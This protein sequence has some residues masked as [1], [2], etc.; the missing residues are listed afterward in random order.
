MRTYVL[1]LFLGSQAVAQESF[2]ET[3]L[4]PVRVSAPVPGAFGSLWT[5]TLLIRNNGAEPV[6]VNG[7]NGY[8]SGL[9]CPGSRTVPPYA[10]VEAQAFGGGH[11]PGALLSAPPEQVQNL[12]FIL[13]IRDLSRQELTWGTEIPVVRDHELRTRITLVGVPVADRFR[14]MLRIYQ[15]EIANEGAAVTVRVYAID[16][17][18]D[19]EKPPDSLLGE[20]VIRLSQLSPNRAWASPGYAEVPDL[21]SLVDLEGASLLALEIEAMEADQRVWAFV[22]VTNNETQHVTTVTPD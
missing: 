20:A 18:R 2:L 7:D 15:P 13:R 22:S 19:S 4:V 16:D 1:L 8:C 17:L 14:N 10:T 9:L 12:S 21:A 3:V 6:M 5:S 11:G